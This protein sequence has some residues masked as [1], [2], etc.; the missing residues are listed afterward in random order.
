MI[1]NQSTVISGLGIPSHKILNSTLLVVQ[2][3]IKNKRWRKYRYVF[4]WISVALCK[5]LLINRKRQS[6][7]LWR[8]HKKEKLKF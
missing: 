6:K 2:K 7:G 3:R 4:C 5:G 8:L 1:Q